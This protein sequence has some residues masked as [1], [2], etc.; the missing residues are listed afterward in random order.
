MSAT[1]L[2]LNV[3]IFQRINGIFFF[4]LMHCIDHG[5]KDHKKY[6]EC[7]NKLLLLKSPAPSMPSSIRINSPMI[8]PSAMQMMTHKISAVPS[9]LLRPIRMVTRA[10]ADMTALVNF[11]LILF[12]NINP[13]ILPRRTVATF[14]NTATIADVS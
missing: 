4:D 8:V 3:F 14:T 13:T 2:F 12:L 5:C 11:S 6:A 1:P 7:C 10:S 9:A